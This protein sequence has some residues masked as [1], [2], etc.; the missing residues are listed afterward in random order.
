MSTHDSPTLG[1]FEHGKIK[2]KA[3]Q[4]IGRAGYLA[5][6]QKDLEQELLVRWLEARKSFDPSMSHLNSFVTT[7]VERD[8]ASILRD[9]QAEKRDHH[10][11]GS[12]NVTINVTGESPTELAQTI[13]EREY[14]SRRRCEPRTNE[15][16][17]Q[18]AIDV[19]NTMASLPDDLREL[20]EGLKT[21]S[22]AAI[23][24]AKG[25]PRTTLNESVRHLRKRFEKVGL[26]EYL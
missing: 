6:D 21:Q 17:A 16:L 12:I 24:R 19:A 25:V 11:I 7:V 22:I 4:I 8:V 10:R 5:Q 3:R 1:D 9:A 18:L 26:R 23:A 20:A 2:T 14:N 15:E 13:G